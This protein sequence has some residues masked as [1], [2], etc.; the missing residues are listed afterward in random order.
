MEEKT[1]ENFK[2]IYENTYQMLLKFVVIN[3]YNFDDVNDI[4]QDTYVVFLN[5][6]KKGIK[7]QDKNS[8]LCGIAK[9]IIK[10]FY[11]GKKLKV[12]S[13]DEN[14][15]IKDDINLEE[16]FITKENVKE[17]WEYVNKKDVLIAKIFYLYY[18]CDLKILE[19]AEE[20]NLTESTVKH[21]LYRTLDEL[22]N[23]YRKDVKND[24]K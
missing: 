19:I 17:I 23:K 21:K 22:K 20:L 9:N 15:E 7:I 18:V 5:K 8:Y 10:R 16:E 1:E 4:I 14:I 24:E 11:F 6:I 13:N 3:C 2:E 12:I